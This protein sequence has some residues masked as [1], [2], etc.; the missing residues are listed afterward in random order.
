MIHSN[1]PN[2]HESSLGIFTTIGY[3]YHGE[4]GK[5]LRLK[6]WESGIN[7]NAY[8]RGIVIHSEWYVSSKFINAMGYA[9]RT[10]GC[11]AVNPDHI[12]RL[13]ELLQDGSVLFVYATPEKNDPLVDHHFS[14]ADQKLYNHI[15][16]TN[17]NPFVRFF[18]SF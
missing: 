18:E 1:T 8:Y 7:N 16:N 4:F 10:W 5:S 3:E 12:D 13:I 14:Y 9:G 6:G 11:F 17:S 15:T 2:S